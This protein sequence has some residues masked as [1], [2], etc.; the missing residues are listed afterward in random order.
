M[1][2]SLQ[3]R[4]ITMITINLDE[5]KRENQNDSAVTKAVICAWD[6]TRQKHASDG[7]DGNPLVAHDHLIGIMTWTQGFGHPDIYVNLA[8]PPYKAWLVATLGRI[9]SNRS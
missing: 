5:C 6:R 1:V 8:Y 3:L 9:A 4:S 7:D 2:H